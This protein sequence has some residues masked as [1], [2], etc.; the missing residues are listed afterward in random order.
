MDVSCQLN[1]LATVNTE[2]EAQVPTTVYVRAWEGPEL[3]WM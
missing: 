1:S 3:V 2:K